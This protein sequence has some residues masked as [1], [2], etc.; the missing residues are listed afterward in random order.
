MDF[1][2]YPMD[3]WP[4]LFTP[5]LSLVSE[6]TLTELYCCL[7]LEQP[8]S[9]VMLSIHSATHGKLWVLVFLCSELVVLWGNSGLKFT[10]WSWSAISDDHLHLY[11]EPLDERNNLNTHIFGRRYIISFFRLCNILPIFFLDIIS[12]PYKA[13]LLQ[14]KLTPIICQMNFINKKVGN[15]K[16]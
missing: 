6:V 5:K 4:C 11:L 13:K 12:F 2:Q 9:S 7:L 14:L 8:H 1:F 16:N 10:H 15:R 3:H